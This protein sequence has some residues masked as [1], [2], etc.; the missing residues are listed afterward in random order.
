MYGKR[1][2]LFKTLNVE[3]LSRGLPYAGIN[4]YFPVRRDAGNWK[5]SFHDLCSSVTYRF[6]RLSWPF[7]PLS[8]LFEIPFIEAGYNSFYISFFDLPTNLESAPK[9]L[10]FAFWTDK[11]RTMFHEIT[12]FQTDADTDLNII[13]LLGSYTFAIDR[14]PIYCIKKHIATHMIEYCRSAGERIS[15]LV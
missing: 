13:N 4:K 5:P 3:A 10:R 9:D 6:S 15:L 12:Y 11:S 7:I 8:D 14:V 1:I 2:E